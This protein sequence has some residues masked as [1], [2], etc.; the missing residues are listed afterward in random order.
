MPIRADYP[1]FMDKT[2]AKTGKTRA[3]T[4]KTR[5]KTGKTRAKTDKTRANTDKTRV[6]TDKTRAVAANPY[7]NMDNLST[8]DPD[9]RKRNPKPNMG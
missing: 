8:A 6:K 9:Q 4:D 5:A 3:K 7:P 2:R 1:K